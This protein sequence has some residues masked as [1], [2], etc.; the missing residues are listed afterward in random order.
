MTPVRQ[1]RPGPAA[2]PHSSQP[3]P[4]DRSTVTEQHSDQS[5]G[6]I[7]ATAEVRQGGAMWVIVDVEQ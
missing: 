3:R 2:R 5:G 6:H 4:A 7:N 1:N